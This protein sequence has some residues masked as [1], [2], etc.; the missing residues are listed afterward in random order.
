M[1]LESLKT[2]ALA[3]EVLSPK[4]EYR[5]GCMNDESSTGW[6]I[7]ELIKD[8]RSISSWRRTRFSPSDSYVH[9]RTPEGESGQQEPEIRK[10]GWDHEHCM[11]CM[12]EISLYPGCE[13]EGFADS[14][15]D[16][17]LCFECYEKYVRPSR[18]G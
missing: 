9:R 2:R 10:G 6:P 8:A 11:L 15:D 17:W 16:R 13:P 3:P 5:S 18:H 4:I 7:P 1:P 12:K 14:N